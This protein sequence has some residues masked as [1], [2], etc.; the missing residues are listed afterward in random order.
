MGQS[1]YFDFDK[2]CCFESDS[3]NT[4]ELG[5]TAGRRGV[6]SD[7]RDCWTYEGYF[8][9]IRHGNES[10]L[11]KPFG[12][13]HL[14]D[15]TKFHDVSPWEPST[16]PWAIKSSGWYYFFRPSAPLSSPCPIWVQLFAEEVLALLSLKRTFLL[17]KPS[18]WCALGLEDN[19]S[20]KRCINSFG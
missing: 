14:T 20:Q 19:V 11:V 18:T 16:E 10:V 4:H 8:Q 7:L 17:D 5:P 9:N 6:S 1:K 13:G 2:Q 12:T 15:A 3:I